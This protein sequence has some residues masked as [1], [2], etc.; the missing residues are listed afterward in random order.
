[1]YK[2]CLYTPPSMLVACVLDGARIG[3]GGKGRKD[4]GIRPAGL[5][6]LLP[7]AR[8]VV[9]LISHGWGTKHPPQRCPPLPALGAVPARRTVARLLGAT[10]DGQCKTHAKK[11]TATLQSCHV[12]SGQRAA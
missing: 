11:A 9:W 6:R 10:G 2:A 7:K 1:M 4:R 3:S 8:N 5:Q 12:I